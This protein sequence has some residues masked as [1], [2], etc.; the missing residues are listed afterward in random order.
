MRASSIT[1]ARLTF[2]LIGSKR[3]MAKVDCILAASHLQ[4]GTLDKASDLYSTVTSRE[5]AGSFSSYEPS[6]YELQR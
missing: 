4:T 3:M 6:I 1:M 5:N 2:E